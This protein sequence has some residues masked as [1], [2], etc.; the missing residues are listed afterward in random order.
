MGDIRPLCICTHVFSHEESLAVINELEQPF[1]LLAKLMYG[2]GLRISEAIRLRIKDVNFNMRYIVIRDGKGAKDRTTLLPNSLI[3]E[4][5][6][7]V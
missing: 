7:Q 5:K 3:P 1:Q 2:S 6:K 4:L